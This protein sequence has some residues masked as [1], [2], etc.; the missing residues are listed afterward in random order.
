MGRRRH[1]ATLEEGDRL[2]IA[3]LFR[4]GAVANGQYRES[5]GHR[6]GGIVSDLRHPPGGYVQLSTQRIY[7]VAQP[8]YLGGHQWY[9]QCPKTGRPVSVVWR[10][11]GSRVFMSR[12][13]YGAQVAYQS[14]F[15]GKE[16]LA[17]R[18][19][20]KLKLKLCRRGAFN[21]DEW[22]FPPKPKW[23]RLGTYRMLEERFDQ[24]DAVADYLLMGRVIPG[25][26][27]ALQEN[28]G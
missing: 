21:P 24:Y 9:F 25:L 28:R 15:L 22:E 26:A 11:L 8:R 18:G 20:H 16:D 23:M 13:A 5:T 10:P 19:M 27:R 6:L 7:L 2:D 12:Q 4:I 3:A 14:Q 1:R 17:A